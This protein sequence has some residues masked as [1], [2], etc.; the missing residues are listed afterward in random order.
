MNGEKI[1][2]LVVYDSWTGNVERMA[3]AV[4]EGAVE[5]GA[6]VKVVKVDEVNID[7]VPIYD[8]YA[9]GSP[10][11]CGTMSYKMNYFF[12]K[13]LIKYWGKLRY[14]VAVAFT[15]SG[16]LSGG[17]E[18]AL[19]SIISAILNFGM[20]TFGVPDYVA[21]G[22]TLHYGAIAI[23][24][25]DENSLKAC[26]LLGKKLVEHIRVIKTSLKMLELE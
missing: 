25:P 13:Q 17:N 6:E 19:W 16:G 1:K 21:H 15:S 22:V 18:M 2:V 26:R 8:G 3:K 10:T 23:G 9:F 14:K 20:M 12:N 7:E 5:E 24:E 11:H 4:A